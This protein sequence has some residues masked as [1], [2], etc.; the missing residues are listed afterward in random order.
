MSVGDWFGVEPFDSIRGTIMWWIPALASNRSHMDCTGLD[1]DY[2]LS[3]SLEVW[4]RT[5]DSNKV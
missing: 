3:S 4:V 5:Y 1:I 2:I